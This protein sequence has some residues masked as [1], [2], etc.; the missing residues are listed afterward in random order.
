MT[1][2]LMSSNSPA[3]S[4]SQWTRELA[5][6][7]ARVDGYKVMDFGAP[8]SELRA[9]RSGTVI[10]DLSHLGLISATGPDVAAFLQG[11]LSSD[12]RQLDADHSQLSSYNSPKGRVLATLLL[13]RIGDAAFLQ[14]PRDLVTDIRKRLTMFVLRSKVNLADTS[15]EFVRLGIAGEQA[16]GVLV[17]VLG[18]AP[19]N[20]FGV[21]HVDACSV[22]RLPGDCFQVVASY[23]RS[24]SLWRDLARRARPAG[25]AVWEWLEI[26]TG[27]PTVTLPTQDQ[28]V[29]QMMNLERVGGVSFQKGCYPGQEI[30]A[31]TQYLGTIKRRTY[32][33]HIEG[34]AV[35]VPGSALYS[36][37]VGDQ[38]SGAVVNAAPAP[39]GGCDLLAVIQVASAQSQLIHLG[40]PAGPVLELRTLPYS[41]A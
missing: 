26:Q 23:A 2:D 13:Y 15:E 29:P 30:V 19:S 18:T 36:D 11:Q 41:L 1:I 27:I 31:R 22:I 40:S 4:A 20:A 12:V 24:S 3:T 7:G 21:A 16:E 35:P 8:E 37:D 10:C 17:S 6:L 25:A 38:P 28:F 33:A 9:A 39:G 32:L 5:T 14:L 34:N